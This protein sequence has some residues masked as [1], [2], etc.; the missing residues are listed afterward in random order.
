MEWLYLGSLQTPQGHRVPPEAP[1]E[2]HCTGA[3][4]V[5]IGPV[6]NKGHLAAVDDDEEDEE[7]D[8]GEEEEA[9]EV[10]RDS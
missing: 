7:E 1:A 4:N 5:S 2:L 6:E 8:D 10:R 9:T 3:S